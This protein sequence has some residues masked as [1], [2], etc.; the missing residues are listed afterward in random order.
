LKHR[1]FGIPP[2][3]ELALVFAVHVEQRHVLRAALLVEPLPRRTGDAGSAAPARSPLPVT[4]TQPHDVELIADRGAVVGFGGDRRRRA[5]ALAFLD[6]PG[7]REIVGSPGGPDLNGLEGESRVAA[8][9]EQSADRP[10]RAEVV[11]VELAVRVA[12]AGAAA[13]LAS[14]AAARQ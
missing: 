10:Q 9:A 6:P 2:E 5:D 14:L 11:Y 4:L 8:V 1:A 7:V 12:G 3:P 13:D